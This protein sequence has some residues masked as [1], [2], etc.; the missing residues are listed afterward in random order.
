[1]HRQEVE[2]YVIKK[3]TKEEDLNKYINKIVSAVKNKNN[4]LP[5][6]GLILIFLTTYF[7]NPSY[8]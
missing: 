7:T 3:I 4:Q 1:M 5:L 2:D 8:I 6:T